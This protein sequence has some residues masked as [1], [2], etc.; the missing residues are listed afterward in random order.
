[1]IK[2]QTACM[3]YDR[4]S[5]FRI[6]V[7]DNQIWTFVGDREIASPWPQDNDVWVANWPSELL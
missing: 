5:D 7:S 1:M 3:A 6:E 2:D 4:K